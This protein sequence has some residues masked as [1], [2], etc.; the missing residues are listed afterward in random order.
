MTDIE[1]DFNIQN[2]E[3]S[4]LYYLE[5]NIKR[6]MDKY[7]HSS[8]TQYVNKLEHGDLKKHSTPI[9]KIHLEVDRSP[10]LDLQGTH[11]YQKSIGICHWLVDCGRIDICYAVSSLSRFQAAPQEG[12]LG[13]VKKTLECL[14]KYKGRGIIY[15]NKKGQFLTLTVGYS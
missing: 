10:L 3:D 14:K 6:V 4:P 11:H 15:Y 2:I 1:Q 12:H 5:N 7:V 9:G 13:L 8:P